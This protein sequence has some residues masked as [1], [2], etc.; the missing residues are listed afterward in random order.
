M[1][2]VSVLHMDWT[3]Q[4]APPPTVTLPTLI[5]LVNFLI[6]GHTSEISLE[7]QGE[8]LFDRR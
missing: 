6:M 5:C 2:R 1:S 7:N 3:E 8:R 4:G